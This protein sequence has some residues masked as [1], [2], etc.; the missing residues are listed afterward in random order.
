VQFI[1]IPTSSIAALKP[2]FKK[3][4]SISWYTR[5]CSV[6]S[7]RSRNNSLQNIHLFLYNANRLIKEEIFVI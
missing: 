4:Q 1:A 2:E 6:E 3:I 5:C 7:T